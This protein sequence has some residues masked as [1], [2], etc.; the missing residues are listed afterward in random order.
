MTLPE[1]MFEKGDYPVAVLSRGFGSASVRTNEGRCWA[2]PN[3]GEL[4]VE[5]EQPEAKPQSHVPIG[6]NGKPRKR[7]PRAILMVQAP[8][9]PTPPVAPTINKCVVFK[10]DSCQRFV[11]AHFLPPF[12]DLLKKNLTPQ[13]AKDKEMVFE[14]IKTVR[15]LA[16]VSYFP[17]GVAMEKVNPWEGGLDKAGE[18][19]VCSICNGA[20]DGSGDKDHEEC[21]RSHKMAEAGMIGVMSS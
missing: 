16:G 5:E 8:P 15:E 6:K 2:T 17:S 11:K 14:Y 18:T 20:L 10:V 13:Q 4:W 19:T 1:N 9:I 12:K 21:I 7:K 3:A